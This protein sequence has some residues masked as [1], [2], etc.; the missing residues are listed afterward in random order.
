MLIPVI[1]H[2]QGPNLYFIYIFRYTRG[3]RSEGKKANTRKNLSSSITLTVQFLYFS[4][5]IHYVPP[6]F[7]MPIPGSSAASFTEFVSFCV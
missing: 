4:V 1:G 3:L 7:I 6:V 5:P 2:D